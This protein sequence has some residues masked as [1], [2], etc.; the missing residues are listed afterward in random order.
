MRAKLK[1]RS[2][3][4]LP[5]AATLIALTCWRQSAIGPA[6]GVEINAMPG[7]DQVPAEVGDISLGAASCRVDSLKIQGQV[8]DFPLRRSIR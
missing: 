7:L 1:I 6:F 3:R 5:G 2:M 8:H 4:V